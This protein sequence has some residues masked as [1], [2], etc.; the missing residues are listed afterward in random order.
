M[1]S[2]V[3]I[4]VTEVITTNLDPSGKAASELATA[5]AAQ[6]SASGKKNDDVAVT[7]VKDPDLTPPITEAHNEKQ[8][9]SNPDY[10]W[11]LA[12]VSDSDGV[13]DSNDSGLADWLESQI[14]DKRGVKFRF[15]VA[16]KDG[17][18]SW[19]NK[20]TVDKFLKDPSSLTQAEMDE[21]PIRM[22]AYDSAGNKIKVLG[23]EVYGWFK[24]PFNL[25][26]AGQN[27]EVRK[28]R[29]AIIEA[30]SAGA[31]YETEI[32]SVSTGKLKSIDGTR[33]DPRLYFD[34]PKSNGEGKLLVSNGIGLVKNTDENLEDTE[35]VDA[36]RDFVGGLAGFVFIKTRS[37]DGKPFPLKLNSRKLNPNEIQSVMEVLA[38]YANGETPSDDFTGKSD[39][40]G[41][42]NKDI[43]DLLIYTGQASL[44]KEYPFYINLNDKPSSLTFGKDK[45]KINFSELQ[46]PETQKKVAESLAT[47]W[48]TTDAKNLNKTMRDTN[49]GNGTFTWFGE[50]I[51]PTSSYNDFQFSQGA[52]STN[53][54]FPSNR[55]FVQPTVILKSPSKW[56]PIGFK[57]EKSSTSSLPGTTAAETDKQKKL[58]EKE[59]EVK[60]ANDKIKPSEVNNVSE[61]EM[62]DQVKLG[63]LNQ[64][65]KKKLPKNK[66]ISIKQG[67]KKNLI[68]VSFPSAGK[69]VSFD[70][71]KNAL[72]YTLKLF[73]DTIA[74]INAN[75]NKKDDTVTIDKEIEYVQVIEKPLTDGQYLNKLVESFGKGFDIKIRKGKDGSWYLNINGRQQTFKGKDATQSAISSVIANREKFKIKGKLPSRVSKTNVQKTNNK[76]R[77]K[78]PYI[79]NPEAELKDQVSED[80]II[81]GTQIFN[82]KGKEVP[83]GGRIY[84]KVF[85]NYRIA[86]GDAVVV[87]YT[88]IDKNKNEKKEKFVVNRNNVIMTMAASTS[89]KIVYTEESSKRNKIKDLASTAFKIASKKTEKAPVKNIVKKT[90]PKDINEF[91]ENKGPAINKKKSVFPSSVPEN[92]TPSDG[93]IDK[94][95]KV[96]SLTP[97]I[98][99]GEETNTGKGKA[100]VKKKI[101]TKPKAATL[102]KI[103][104]E[105]KDNAENK[106]VFSGTSKTENAENLVRQMIKGKMITDFTPAEQALIDT[107]PIERKIEIE[108]EIKNNPG[109]VNS[110]F[111]KRKT[112]AD[113]AQEIENIRKILPNVPVEVAKTFIEGAFGGLAEGQFYKGVVTIA[114][115]ANE[116]I[117]YHEGFHAVMDGY[118]TLRER[119]NLLKKVQNKYGVNP[120]QAEEIL[121]EE[122][123]EYM[124]SKRTKD[125]PN[126]LRWIYDLLMDLVDAFRSNKGKIFSKI[127]KGRFDYIPPFAHSERIINDRLK[128]GLKLEVLHEAI[129]HIAYRVI[130]MTGV[131]SM[132]LSVQEGFNDL[133][134]IFDVIRKDI[135][136]D[137]LIAY[138]KGEVTDDW[139]EF[140][141]LE[142]IVN[143]QNKKA[144]NWEDIVQLVKDELQRFSLLETE[145][146]T[147][148]TDINET[149]EYDGVSGGLNIKPALTYS[150][151]DNATHNTRFMV[152]MLSDP[153]ASSK[154]F[155]GNFKKL[156]K[157]EVSWRL[158]EDSLANIVEDTSQ[159]QVDKMLNKIKDLAQTHPEFNELI[160]Q[161]EAPEDVFPTF[162]KIQFYRAFSKQKV[163]YNHSGYN[164]EGDEYNV[165]IGNADQQSHAKLLESQFIENFNN[166]FI[167]NGEFKSDTGTKRS[168]REELTEVVNIFKSI[169]EELLNPETFNKIENAERF[170]FSYYVTISNALNTLGI[171]VSPSS[172]QSYVMGSQIK[173]ETSP[174]VWENVTNA[175]EANKFKK[176]FLNSIIYP[177]ARGGGKNPKTGLPIGYAKNNSSLSLEKML[178]KDYDFEKEEGKNFIEDHSLFK[179]LASIEGYNKKETLENMVLGPENNLYWTKSLNNFISKSVNQWKQDP[180][181]LVNLLSSSAYHQSSKWAKYLLGDDYDF[182]STDVQE[183]DE[184][185]K[186]R[187]EEF[188]VQVY[189]SN[190]IEND[191]TDQGTAFKNM[192]SVDMQIDSMNK[193]LNGV[194]FKNGSVFSPLTLADKSSHFMFTGLP[195]EQYRINNGPGSL[196]QLDKDGSPNSKA[197]ED[198]YLYFIG[199]INRYSNAHES[200]GNNKSGNKYFDNVGSKKL[201]WFP[202]LSPN[203]PLANEI[204][205]FDKDGLVNISDKEVVKK[206]KL[207]IKETIES[208]HEKAIQSLKDNNI[209]KE[210]TEGGKTIIGIDST[211]K[212]HYE[213]NNTNESSAVD[214]LVLDYIVN[215]MTANIEFTML[216]TGDPAFYKDLSKRTPA[217]SGQGTDLIFMRGKDGKYLT[218][219]KYS[220]LVIKDADT[221]TSE[222]YDEYREHLRSHKAVRNNKDVRAY[223]EEQID[224]ILKPYSKTKLNKGDGQ[225]FISP[226]RYKS[227]M[228]GLGKWDSAADEAFERLMDKD[229][230]PDPRDLLSMQ[231]L[232]GMHFELRNENGFA[233]PTYLK[234]S[235]AVLW[236]ALVKGTQHEALLER[237]MDENNPIDEVVYESGVKSGAGTVYSKEQILNGKYKTTTLSNYHWKLQ[238]DLPTKY[239]AKGEALVGSQPRKNIF[240]N[241]FE[242]D[243]KGNYKRTYRLNGEVLTADQMAEKINTIESKLSNIG[244]KKFDNKYGVVNGRITNQEPVYE[245]LIEKFKNDGV[246]MNVIEQLEARV[247]LSLIFQHSDK[248]EQEIFAELK[249]ATIKLTSAGGSFVQIAGEGFAQ[250]S[251]YKKLPVH[252]KNGI[253]HLVDADNGNLKGPRIREDGSLSAQ[254]YL[255]FKDIENIPGWEKMN[256]KQLKEALGDT[257]KN[258]VGYRIP[259]QKISGMDSLEIVGILPP[260][261]GDSIVVYDEV[262]GK[263]GSDFDIDKMYVMMYNTVFNPKAGRLERINKQ[264]SGLKVNPKNKKKYGAL[265]RT[266]MILENERLEMWA[267]VLESKDTFTDAILPVDTAWLKNEAYY[268]HLLD[269]I[270]KDNE[271]ASDESENFVDNLV[272]E[273]LGYKKNRDEFIKWFKNSEFSENIQLIDR[274]GNDLDSRTILELFVTSPKETRDEAA[275]QFFSE[276][277]GNSLE[278]ASPFTQ[279]EIRER[280]LGG[281][282]GV[283]ITANHLTHH[284]LLQAVKMAEVY[285]TD[286]QSISETLSAYMNA[287]VDNAKDPFISLINNNLNTANTVFYMIR[288]GIPASVVNRI[289]SLPEIKDYVKNIESQNS[290]LVAKERK[291]HL[292]I[293]GLSQN[294]SL[295]TTLV[296]EGV[297]SPMSKTFEKYF[298]GVSK[299]ELEKLSITDPSTYTEEDFDQMI[300]SGKSDP[301][302]LLYFMSMEKMG[303]DF[304]KMVTASKYDT[305]GPGSGMAD[306]V[307][308]QNLEKQVLDGPFA[309][310]Y[311]AILDGTFV[312]AMK[313]N[314]SDDVQTLMSNLFSSAKK[315]MIELITKVSEAIGT[316]SS[317]KQLDG[318]DVE[319]NKRIIKTYQSYAFS[320]GLNIDS[321]KTNEMFFG[322]RSMAKRLIALRNTAKYS[323]NPFLQSF[324]T[325]GVSK[326]GADFI[327][328]PSSK[329]RD[330]REKDKLWTEWESLYDNE[331]TREFAKDLIKYAYASSGFQ[332]NINSFYDLIPNTILQKAMEK[333]I[334]PFNN[335]MQNTMADGVNFDNFFD[336]FIAHNPDML[337]SHNLSDPRF[338]PLPDNRNVKN[339]TKAGFSVK[340]K[341]IPFSFYAD[342]STSQLRKFITLSPKGGKPY[343]DVD[344]VTGYKHK[345]YKLL[346][347]HIGEKGGQQYYK[348]V[349]ILGMSEKGNHIVEYKYD[350]KIEK[351]A[352]SPFENTLMPGF[353]DSITSVDTKTNSYILNED[354]PIFRDGNEPVLKDIE[355]VAEEIVE[356]TSNINT[357]AFE[358]NIS[359]EMFGENDVMV[360]G[361]NSAGG[362]G[363]GVAALAYANTTKNYRNWNPN[364]V[365]DIQNKKTGDFAIAGETGLSV[366]NKGTGYGLVTKNASVQN[367]KLKMGQPL[368]YVALGEKIEELYNTAKENPNKRFIIPYNSDVNLNKSNLNQLANAFGGAGSIPPNVFF[369]D[370]MLAEIKR[371]K[372]TEVFET[373]EQT[374][375]ETT[376]SKL[377]GLQE[378]SKQA[379]LATVPK[380][381]ID[382]T[383][384][385]AES[386]MSNQD[387]SEIL[388]LK[389]AQESLF[390]G[391]DDV[392]SEEQYDR[393]VKKAKESEEYKD[394]QKEIDSY[395]SNE[396]KKDE[397]SVY[398]LGDK[399]LE[400]QSNYVSRKLGKE[401]ESKPSMKAGAS[402]GNF[403]DNIGRDIFDGGKVKTLKEYVKEADAQNKE[404][405]FTLSNISQEQFDIL[406]DHL[407]GIKNSFPD[408]NFVSK[409][410]FLNANFTA[411]QIKAQGKDGI[412]G[413]LD[414]LGVDSDGKLHIIDFKNKIF[415]KDKQQFWDKNL[416]D[417][418][419][420]ESKLTGWSRQLSIYKEMLEQKGFEVAT[421]SILLIPTEYSYGSD[422]IFDESEG[423]TIKFDKFHSPNSVGKPIPEIHQSSLSPELIDVPQNK[424]MV[425]QFRNDTEADVTENKTTE[426]KPKGED[427][428]KPP[429]IEEIKEEDDTVVQV[430]RIETID[431]FRIEVRKEV[432]EGETVY[433]AYAVED[434]L[435]KGVDPV[436]AA[437]FKEGRSLLP[438]AA[439]T[440]EEAVAL[441]KSKISRFDIQG[442]LLS[443]NNAC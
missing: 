401:T 136:N 241:M 259:N 350:T 164:I 234:Y 382:S 179:L 355:E 399:V 368:D 174:N 276:R 48:R 359:Q 377:D 185:G 97:K 200:S 25:N 388:A 265:K 215:A 90:E 130:K 64:V 367:G 361:A 239:E 407:T 55:L 405:G 202:E 386:G 30:L 213:N 24:L 16:K 163:I 248:I 229:G 264:N 41:I 63:D 246:D 144:D 210:N 79:T 431:G 237:M 188:A 282:A 223:T 316:N 99:T 124:L 101:R 182:D 331:E 91:T 94:M 58:R 93:A 349:P 19:S 438:K 288:N 154:Y 6:L 186:K 305:D 50:E 65:L 219:K 221:E 231:P 29:T 315:P 3:M 419:K 140:D 1:E 274:E 417:D 160:Q 269:Y 346:Y 122:F 89:G 280:N 277:P 263:T 146:I 354:S 298:N 54:E 17:D 238:Q 104:Q 57:K 357:P 102:S 127:R 145:A 284:N 250:V 150:G 220:L 427:L 347:E 418:G 389:E 27:E 224:A 47:M 362:H 192:T 74:E 300:L 392:E 204:G 113:I 52:L 218:P 166:K 141:Q 385:N 420:F 443:L 45:T 307:A 205:L 173:E 95:D 51:K 436:I 85:A 406:V 135:I 7:D 287:Y 153:N 345:T 138:D 442:L 61:G 13:G 324:S 76:I 142:L 108:K 423:G 441:A 375:A 356:T 194:R 232:K 157:Y 217:T 323:S 384:S 247:P 283:G 43:I 293:V 167:E 4:A 358:G 227:L 31:T 245:H 33:K 299:A 342:Q 222:Q 321:K 84:N 2:E 291:T 162:K 183:L 75:P 296:K 279:N 214:A 37:L 309:D 128:G 169:A 322:K 235:Q 209:I 233:I 56:T 281:K 257:I 172:L 313:T 244:K 326:E 335:E 311:M 366:G 275:A 40:S 374:P 115:G 216:F 343:I 391:P 110:I 363:Q 22:V 408:M 312:G 308:K 393:Y 306:W 67:G 11:S 285:G 397:E 21:L 252:N 133:D 381:N 295:Q 268:L 71:Y 328:F 199:E 28:A 170:D 297:I 20:A 267:S 429:S 5:A 68:T 60:A 118:L 378:I 424:E 314:A 262:T 286:G 156:A 319:F 409:E 383:L 92:K 105:T 23:K 289:L 36:K 351:S 376:M 338:I 189:L 151:K 14:S 39:I 197:V 414:L 415:N 270:S 410:L 80:Y 230:N 44:D 139:D 344:P 435:V 158:L 294:G 253:R 439:S 59:E 72:E 416:Y 46:N 109:A 155:G 249:K 132:D 53:A 310:E 195:M 317:Y 126:S 413:T 353:E 207:H 278:F 398:K 225:G 387:A 49:V 191:S 334:L 336:Q 303:R 332:K 175:A 78:V 42:R 228:I 38:A 333:G 66:M 242:K 433:Q 425:E 271:A 8:G 198:M 181:T 273:S 365:D 212:T 10:G 82:S 161:L 371:V 266:Q 177:F 330:P 390:P 341:S 106:D 211:I 325:M 434:T 437:D 403:V 426:T 402:V 379:S 143:P 428:P 111:S 77:V 152:K 440:Q 176:Q 302:L 318:T 12:Y 171:E 121:A 254:V 147:D 119:N 411:E 373:T 125:I 120:A 148:K 35:L 370:N 208:Q 159:D 137:Q 394:L 86:T 395:Y 184:S 34:A 9:G 190:R 255:P 258:I 73:Q 87:E 421:T 352:V 226:Q 178:S 272:G 256:D 180:Q 404:N 360:F 116:G 400:R 337:P 260:A 329:K 165:K 88:V 236:P 432:V 32:E 422:N 69:T 149:N 83:K 112:E 340:S 327:T 320:N 412:G 96:T 18:Q 81:D 107:V 100:E 62:T 134:V 26:V 301:G 114:N 98:A 15:E 201:T 251:S 206:V 117:A 103:E 123:R 129:D 396:N 261:A 196:I 240:Q 131:R 187:L 372:G 292:K 380:S 430:F 168:A 364:L 70:N 369:G 243:A 290:K 348:R 339:K 193:V 304:N 203:T